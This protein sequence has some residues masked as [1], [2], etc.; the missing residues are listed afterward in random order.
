MGYNLKT[1]KSWD[2]TIRELGWMFEKWG[3][4]DWGTEPRRPDLRKNYWSVSERRV[5][6]TFKTRKGE[7]RSFSMDKQ[8]RPVDNLRV[9][10]LALE[11]IRMNES[12]GIGDVV[13]EMY[14]ALPAPPTER[15]PYEVLGIRPDAE[16]ALVEAAYKAKARQLGPPD[17]ANGEAFR[18]L[19]A[20]RE[21]ALGKR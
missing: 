18:E 8:E 3:I 6:V 9:L 19:N 20:A 12:R 1:T 4:H 13:R 5:T 11:A 14:M 2:E 7:M 21:K 15:D 17:A 16:E 10:Y